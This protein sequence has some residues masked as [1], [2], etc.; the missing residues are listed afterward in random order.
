MQWS[1]HV[2]H[3][4]YLSL[5]CMKTSLPWK[6][7]RILNTILRKYKTNKN[8][9]SSNIQNSKVTFLSVTLFN[10]TVLCL[11]FQIVLYISTV[12]RF[13]SPRHYNTRLVSS[14]VSLTKEK[15]AS[16]ALVDHPS[17]DGVTIKISFGVVVLL[18]WLTLH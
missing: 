15:G 4:T 5:F 16:L 14:R 12:H 1:F 11:E 10:I 17:S 9:E 18:H 2:K 7:F 6:P 8:R 3:G 13:V